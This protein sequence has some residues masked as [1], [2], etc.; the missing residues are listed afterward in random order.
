MEVSDAADRS[1]LRPRAIGQCVLLGLDG[2]PRPQLLR[3]VLAK[4]APERPKHFPL[5]ATAVSC[6]QRRLSASNCR[7]ASSQSESASPD[8]ASLR[9]RSEMKYARR[10]T[11]SSKGSPDGRVGS[12]CGDAESCVVRPVL[13]FLAAGLR[14]FLTVLLRRALWR[15]L[16]FFVAAGALDSPGG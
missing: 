16:V 3:A 15:L 5:Y 13:S 14:V 1:F 2:F 7:L 11:S 8:N 6:V 4:P 9:R 12:A 10:R